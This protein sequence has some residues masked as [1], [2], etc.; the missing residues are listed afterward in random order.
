MGRYF[1]IHQRSVLLLTL[2]SLWNLASADPACESLAALTL[3]NTTITEA[4]SVAAGNFL[5]PKASGGAAGRRAP[6]FSGLPAFCRVAATI[7]PTSDSDIR[8]EVWMPS[9][10]NWNGKLAGVGS[11]GL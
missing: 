9:R 5:L 6:D 2:A 1:V 4:K 7:K 3:P 10:E 11:G 8:I